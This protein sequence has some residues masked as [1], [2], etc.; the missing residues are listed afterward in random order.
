MTNQVTHF[1]IHADDLDRARRFYSTVFGWRY[2]G[3]GGGPMH[4]FCMIRGPHGE[5]LVPAGAIQKRKFNVGPNPI[6]GF[7]CTIEVQDLE[8]TAA[9][10]EAEGGR[11]VMGRTAV[12]GVG[13]LVKFLD[14][15][16]NLV[17]AMKFDPAAH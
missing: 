6:Y 5:A 12:A 15:E 9:A 1:A 3:F 10:V 8:A 13:W 14:T 11:I 7:E 4:D 2:E 17:C 16:Q